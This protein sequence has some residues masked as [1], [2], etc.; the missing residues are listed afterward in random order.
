MRVNEVTG[1]WD[2]EFGNINE[3]ETDKPC[4]TK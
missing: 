2:Y 4:R 3:A 1:F